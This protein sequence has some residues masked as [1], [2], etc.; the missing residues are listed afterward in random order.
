MASASTAEQHG[1]CTI[2]ARIEF[3]GFAKS[4]RKYLTYQLVTHN[5]ICIPFTGLAE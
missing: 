3:Y 1:L 2:I 4:V 5:A